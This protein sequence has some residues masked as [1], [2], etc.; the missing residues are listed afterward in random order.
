MTAARAMLLRWLLGSLCALLAPAWAAAATYTFRSDSFAWESASTAVTWERR[1]T[2]Y[3]GDDD[4]ATVTFTGGFTFPFAGT[5]Y[6]SVRVLSNGMLQF[7]ADTGFFRNFTNTRLPAGAASGRSGCVAA[8][9]ARTMMVYWADLD[10]G[11]SAASGGGVTWQ[12]KGTAPNRYVVVSW[13]AVFQYSTSTP[14]TFQVILYESGEFKFQYGNANASGSNATIGVQ[15]SDSD[16]TLYA[17]NS[18]YNANGSAI[19]WVRP[20]TAPERVAE[21]Y[22]DGFALNGT[23]GEVRDS[24]GNDRNGVRVGSAASVAGGYVCRGVEIPANTNATIAAIDTLLS[25]PGAAGT[26]GSVSMWWRSAVVWTA[27]T[28]A[29]LFD[30]TQAAARPFYLQRNGGGALRFALTDGAGTA[31]S[32]TTAASAF[33]AG[34]WVHVTATWRLAAGTNQSTLRIFVNGALAATTIGTTSGA[35]D[36]GQGTLFLGDNR[37]SA[38]PSGGSLNSANGR[39]DEVRVYNFDQGPGDIAADMAASHECQP[40]VDHYEVSLPSSSIACL[41]STVTVTACADSS[42][43]CTNRAAGLLGQTATLSTSAA[44]LGSP[45]LVFDAN[46]VASTTLSFPTAS[47]G[48]VVAVSLSNESTAATAPRQCCPDG[49]ACSAANS[50]ATTFRTAG[51]VI[52]AAAGASEAT[53]PAQTAGTA[54]A[55]HFLRAVQTGTSTKACEAALTGANAVD[56]ASQCNNP[57]TCSSGNRMTVTGSSAVAVPGNPG[58]G[59]SSWASVPM[60]FD[61]NG[62]APFSV[63]L[64]DVGQVSL[65]V[66]RLGAGLQTTPL[67]G[68]SNAYVTRPAGFTVTGIR[69]TA[70]PGT[71]NP[72]AADAAGARFVAAGESFSATITATTSSGAAAPNF[73]RETVPEGVLLTPAL[74]APA[75]GA[76]GTLS[77]GSVAGSSFSAGVA[78]V[79]ALAF[80]EV[81]IVRLTPSVADGNY[82]GAGPVSGSASVTIGRFVPARFVVSGGSATHRSALACSPASTFSYLGENFRLGLTLAAQNSAGSTTLNYAGAFAKFDPAA[83]GAW[84]LAGRDGSTVFTAAGGRLALGS[85]SGSW[86]AGVAAGVTL[87]AQATRA[88]SPDG[89]FNADFGVAPTDSDGVTLAAPDMASTAGGGNDRARVATLPLHFGRLRLANAIGPADRELAVPVAAQHWTGSTFDTHTL[90]S[91]TTLPAASVSFG[92]L[93]RTLTTADTAVLGSVTLAAGVGR[94]RLAAPQ[95]GRSGTYDL[96]LSLGGGAADASCLQPW[97]PGAGDAA[98]AGANLAHLRGAW[99]GGAFGNDPSARASFGLASGHEALVYRRENY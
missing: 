40:P 33:A 23:V 6:S 55:T 77:N 8:A 20:S 12:Q 25:L 94:L 85:A 18:G 47:D 57:A 95:G 35:L 61:S 24:S 60:V 62:N 91:C 5:A 37:S 92:N 16:F 97:T 38:T 83:A 9:T 46:G 50:C 19:R 31:L 17:F 58:S 3:P 71:A 67:T 30:A 89:P 21:Y 74:V 81:G 65:F 22:L 79:T 44:T 10:P 54:S 52:A 90:D 76:A 66:R 45:L 53:L 88:A 29:V 28:P 42:R 98:T 86:T 36:G 7:G 51:F 93:R 26:S 13:N 4:Q 2:Q 96:A 69:Q 70:A 78:T 59:V 39:I 14:Y 56:W 15:V 80:S 1:C 63:S 48:S 72:A 82:L 73:G 43:P 75:G 27:S 11:A 84:N 99:C 64:A 34:T 49:T 68:R 41:G 32:A 87:T